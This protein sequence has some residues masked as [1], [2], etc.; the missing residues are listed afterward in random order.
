MDQPNPHPAE[1]TETA[2][3]RGARIAREEQTI[4]QARRSLTECGGIPL[5]DVEAWVDSWDT[6]DEL[7]M[8][9]K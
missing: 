5:E 1:L 2:E 6:P 7:P 3:E 4:E 8:P 9:R